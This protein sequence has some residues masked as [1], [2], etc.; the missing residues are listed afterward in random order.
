MAQTTRRVLCIEDDPDL[1]QLYVELLAE[2]DCQAI[3]VGTPPPRKTLLALAPDLIL[4]DLVL[5]GDVR[6]WDYLL[7]VRLDPATRHIPL[8]VCTAALDELARREADLARLGVP[9]L[10]KPF[11]IDAWFRLV[12]QGLADDRL[13]RR[14]LMA[15]EG[16]PFMTAWHAVWDPA[17]E[18]YF[19][20]V[21]PPASFD[22]IIT[23]DSIGRPDDPRF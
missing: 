14:R 4:L 13:R 7:A 3:L 18:Y 23:A 9:V 16:E 19:R 22:L 21:C 15:R 11:D 2:I 6:G 17:E 20:Q 12:C 5:S 8:L 10:A 1:Q